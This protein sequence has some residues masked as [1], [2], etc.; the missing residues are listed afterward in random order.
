LDFELCVVRSEHHSPFPMGDGALYYR[1]TPL[2]F[3]ML[4]APARAIAHRVNECL[5]GKSLAAL[6]AEWR[7]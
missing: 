4:S 6:F 1:S 2:A 5:A 3:S 7:R